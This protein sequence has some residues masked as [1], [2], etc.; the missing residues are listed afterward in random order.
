MHP[1]NASLEF[2]GSQVVMVAV[3]AQRID[4]DPTRAIG[5]Q[6]HQ[7]ATARI[8]CRG[9]DASVPEARLANHPIF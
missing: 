1:F 6:Y 2:D 9:D 7:P 8:H 4:L 5:H 3:E